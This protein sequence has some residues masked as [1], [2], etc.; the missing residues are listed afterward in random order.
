M[1]RK[2]EPEG[3]DFAVHADIVME[4]IRART[5]E[6]WEAAGRPAG[7]DLEFWLMAEAEVAER[8]AARRL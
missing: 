2:H 6:L 8:M 4:A 5:R 7:R 1:E 3:R